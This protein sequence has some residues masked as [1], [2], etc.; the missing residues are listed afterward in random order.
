MDYTAIKEQLK[1]YFKNLLIAQYHCSDQNK[2]FIDALS[3]LMFAELLS[4]KIL[5]VCMNVEKSEGAQL[6]QEGE[7]VSVTRDY[8]YSIL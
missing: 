5:N 8:D 6:D 2:M 7:W 4:L 1:E 3:E